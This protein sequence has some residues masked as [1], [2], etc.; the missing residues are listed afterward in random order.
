[1]VYSETTRRNITVAQRVYVLLVAW[2]QYSNLEGR[3][4][5]S[6]NLALHSPRYNACSPATVIPCYVNAEMATMRTSEVR[7][8]P[9]DP[10]F[11]VQS[12][13]AFSNTFFA[14][15]NI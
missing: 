6:L 15:N 10:N 9:P 14:I 3:I 12:G 5:P 2:L 1:M 4:L 8:I 11:R 7:S 13:D